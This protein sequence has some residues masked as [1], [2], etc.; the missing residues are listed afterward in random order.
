M[1]GFQTIFRRC[2]SC[3]KRFEI[4]ITG[5]E[6]VKEELVQDA[7]RVPTGIPPKA[8]VLW[9]Q[10]LPLSEDKPVLVDVKDFQYSYQCKHCGLKWIEMREEEGGPLTLKD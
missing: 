7:L 8:A 9:S 6:L 3:G 5:K 10:V 2:P 1:L 4:R